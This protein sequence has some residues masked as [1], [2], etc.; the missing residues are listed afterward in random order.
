M[1]S[2]V[3]QAAALAIEYNVHQNFAL[4]VI[5]LVVMALLVK[6]PER[7][8]RLAPQILDTLGYVLMEAYKV[9]PETL[10]RLNKAI[11]AELTTQRAS[12]QSGRDQ[13]PGSN[14]D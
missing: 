13:C 12:K 3:N 6:E 14:T 4:G 1:N 11:L 7:L 5:G 9:E 8:Q 2:A 10:E